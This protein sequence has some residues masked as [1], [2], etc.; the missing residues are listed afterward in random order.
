MFLSPFFS[1]IAIL[2]LASMRRLLVI[3]FLISSLNLFSQIPVAE[4]PLHYILYEDEEI[5]VLEIIALPGDTALLHQHDYNYCYIATQGGK[6]WL[7]DLGKESRKVLLPTHYAGGKFNLSEGPFTHRFANIDEHDIRFFTLE[8]K[9]GKVSNTRLESLSHDFI[10][11]SDLFTIRKL[12]LNPLSAAKIP[13]SGT[14]IVLNLSRLPLAY[15]E[16]KEIEYWRRFTS[17]EPIYIQNVSQ[18][19]LQCAIFE[20]Y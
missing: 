11:D 17:K 7:E 8:H 2:Y 16:G 13:H 5:R 19:T 20:V 14:V 10:L 4:E 1:W 12:Q 15:T 9:L 6:M 18:D 3:Y